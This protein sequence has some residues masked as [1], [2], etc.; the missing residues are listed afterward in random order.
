MTSDLQRLV[1]DLVEKCGAL[2]GDEST[3]IEPDGYPN[4]LALCA[5]DSLYSIGITYVATTNVLNRY[6]AHR[7]AVGGDP[8]CDTPSDLLKTFEEVG[9]SEQWATEIAGNKNRTH[10]KPSAI[11]KSE[12]VRQAAVM[13]QELGFKTPADVREAY[14]AEPSLSELK[15][16]WLALP[17]QRSGVSFDYFLILVGLQAV[18]PDRMVIRFIKEQTGA[19][20]RQL[21]TAAVSQLVQEIAAEYP[22]QVR[23]LDH[24]IWRYMTSKDFVEAE[25]L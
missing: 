3:W 18:K 13:L 23:K 4:S 15:E 5:M 19:D 7:R 8:Q 9:G 11:L 1:P 22:T 6:C 24:V 21:S 16:R 12:L 10:S 17:S 2:F 20:A 25:S 14:A